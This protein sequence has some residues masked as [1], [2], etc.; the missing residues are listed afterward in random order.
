MFT[1]VDPN[2]RLY[3][4][5]MH[6]AGKFDG[7]DLYFFAYADSAKVE[8]FKQDRQVNCAFADTHK[9]EFVSIAGT[10]SLTQDRALMEQKWSTPLKA[11]F[12]DGLETKGIALIQV[13]ASD[14]QYWDSRNQL[15]IHAFGVVKAAVTG[16]PVK[17][18]GEN[19]KLNL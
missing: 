11:W 18:A 13:R 14:A 3:S 17:D 15:M 10:A 19:E 12:P 2:G 8:E 9:A 7:H 1:T 4:R 16:E 5:P 6:M